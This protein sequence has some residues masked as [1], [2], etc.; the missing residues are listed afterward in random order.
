MDIC[1]NELSL[2][3]QYTSEDE[4]IEKGL[5]PI[6]ELLRQMEQDSCSLYKTYSLYNSVATVSGTTLHDI[7]VGKL[8]RQRDEIR[9]LKLLFPDY[10]LIP[11]GKI[12]RSIKPKIPILSAKRL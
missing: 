7:L 10:S 8:T 9:R 5:F 3:G 6:I 12:L 1:I 2:T 4:C 11:I